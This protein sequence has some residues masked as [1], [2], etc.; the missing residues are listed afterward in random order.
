M[1]LF[2][3]RHIGT[4]FS[5]FQSKAHVFIELCGSE[6]AYRREHQKIYQRTIVMRRRHRRQHQHNIHL[7]IYVC[8]SDSM[9]LCLLEICC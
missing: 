2:V 4:V 7:L 5:L 8:E 3:V 9:S 6:S 1:L